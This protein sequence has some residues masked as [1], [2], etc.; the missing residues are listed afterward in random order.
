M[1]VSP[2]QDIMITLYEESGVI[3]QVQFNFSFQHSAYFNTHNEQID[4]LRPLDH[5]VGGKNKTRTLAF[6]HDH[7]N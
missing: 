6:L 7:S 3:N 1:E 4:S 2:I 5:L